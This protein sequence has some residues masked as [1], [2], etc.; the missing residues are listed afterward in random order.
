MSAHKKGSVDVE[1]LLIRASDLM[2]EALI[3]LDQAS[4][5]YSAAL[6]DHAIAALPRHT[7][8]PENRG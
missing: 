7:T 4:A 6:L 1:R 8:N 3:L 5:T 2:I